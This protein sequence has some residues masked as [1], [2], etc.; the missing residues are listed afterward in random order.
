MGCTVVG[1]DPSRKDDDV[2]ETHTAYTAGVCGWS[3]VM[4][5]WVSQAVAL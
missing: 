3:W 1:I 2:E 4:P 5:I